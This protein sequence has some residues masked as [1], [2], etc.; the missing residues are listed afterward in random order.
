[1]PRSESGISTLGAILAA[2]VMVVVLV[3]AYFA[4]ATYRHRALKFETSYQAVLLTNGNVYFGR[5]EDYGTRFPVLK[6]VFYVQTTTN[7]ETKQAMNVLGVCPR[8]HLQFY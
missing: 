6:D 4:Q 8:I 1:M 2:A 5:L 7:P 3:A